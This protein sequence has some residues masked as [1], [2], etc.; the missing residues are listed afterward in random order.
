MIA[1]VLARSFFFPLSSSRERA[2][3]VLATSSNNDVTTAFILYGTN[4]SNYRANTKI[5]ATGQSY[6]DRKL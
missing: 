1:V 2:V 5:I 6:L 4:T 3:L